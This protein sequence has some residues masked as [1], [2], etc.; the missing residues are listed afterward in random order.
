MLQIR[1]RKKW[2]LAWAGPHFFAKT[3]KKALLKP[4]FFI[5]CNKLLRNCNKTRE[6]SLYNEAGWRNHPS[7]LE[8]AGFVK[9]SEHARQSNKSIAMH[10]GVL[11]F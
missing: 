10:E 7:Y 4:T 3:G 9:K 1:Y 8:R 2:G 6:K 5:V 11:D